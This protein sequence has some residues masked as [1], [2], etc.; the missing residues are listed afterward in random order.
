MLSRVIASRVLATLRRAAEDDLVTTPAG[1]MRLID[2]LPTR[3]FE[4]TVHTCDLAAVLG[5]PIQVPEAAAVEGLTL[6][7]GLAARTGQAGPLLLAA[8]GRT[9]LPAGFTVL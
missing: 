2:Y 6:I 4:L 3:T 7:G 5:V 9:S 1:G 8:T